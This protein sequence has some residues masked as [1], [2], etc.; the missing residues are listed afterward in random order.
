LV[1]SRE[2]CR[3]R[4]QGACGD[5]EEDREDGVSFGLHGVYGQS[6]DC[7]GSASVVYR[8]MLPTGLETTHTIGKV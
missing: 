1:P 3:A 6:T 8:T 5:C 2:G 7:R 4:N